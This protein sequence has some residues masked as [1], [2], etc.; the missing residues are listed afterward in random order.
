M[1]YIKEEPYPMARK[2]FYQWSLVP[3]CFSSLPED[4]EAV[5][6]HQALQLSLGHII[7]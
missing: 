3:F 6:N 7:L 5:K 1:P 2:F 4:L